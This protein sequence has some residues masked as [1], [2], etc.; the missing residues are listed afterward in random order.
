MNAKRIL[1]FLLTVWIGAGAVCSHAEPVQPLKLDPEPGFQGGVALVLLNYSAGFCGYGGWEYKDRHQ[2]YFRTLTPEGYGDWKLYD[3]NFGEEYHTLKTV[4]DTRK[5]ENGFDSTGRAMDWQSAYCVEMGVDL[6]GQDHPAA[7][8]EAF[9]EF[10]GRL[11]K[12]NPE[13][14]KGLCLTVL[15][16]CTF[17]GEI[18]EDGGITNIRMLTP[19]PEDFPQDANEVD[20]YMATNMI[21]YEFVMGLRDLNGLV[22]TSLCPAGA[23]QLKKELEG[24]PAARV[25]DW[26]I[27]RIARHA[28]PPSF[29]SM[30]GSPPVQIQLNWSKENQ[31]YEALL[32]DTNRTELDLSSWTGQG[33]QIEKAGSYLYRVWTEE[34]ISQQTATIQKPRSNLNGQNI[35]LWNSGSQKQTL[36]TGTVS[37]DPLFFSGVFSTEQLPGQIEGTKTDEEGKGLQGVTIGLF[38]DEREYAR[39]ITQSDGS[40]K[41]EAVP[42]GRYVVREIAALAGYEPTEQKY[43]VTVDRS[44]REIRIP[45]IL[46]KIQ[47]GSA[48]IL[49]KSEDGA[50][51]GFE[52]LLE[53][54]SDA[55]KAVHR[56]ART[57]LT[58]RALLED[59]PAGTYTI[60]EI[61]NEETQR[62]VPAES[63]RI[64]I[65]SNSVTEVSFFNRLKK[66]KVQLF[67]ADAE[68]PD[69][70][71]SGAVFEVSRDGQR[72]GILEE[73]DPGHYV[74]DQLPAGSYEL[75][76][77]EAPP[78]YAADPEVYPFSITEDGEIVTIENSSGETIHGFFNRAAT[79]NLEIIKIVEKDDFR[80]AGSG[81]FQF[82]V[83]G[84]TDTGEEWNQVYETD[85]DGRILIENLKT[86]EYT[87]TELPSEKTEGMLLPEDRTIRI[88]E[89]KTEKA[90]FENRWIRGNICL[91]KADAEFP[92]KRLQGAVFEIQSLDGSVRK[93]LQEFPDG[94]YRYEDLAYGSYVIREIKA[95]EHYVLPDETFPIEIR[96]DGEEIWIGAGEL[97]IVANEPERG[98]LIIHKEVEEDN[99][100]KISAKGFRFRVTGQADTGQTYDQTF[101]TDESGSIRVKN[102][103]T[104]LYTISE[105]ADGQMERLFD[106]PPDQTVRLEAGKQ[107]EVFVQNKLRRGKLQIF[108]ASA[109]SAQQRLSGAEFVL[110]IMKNNSRADYTEVYKEQGTWTEI[111]SKE[112]GKDGTLEFAQLVPGHYRLTETKSPEGYELLTE[113]IC[114][115]IPSEEQMEYEISLN[116]LNEPSYQLPDTGG[117]GLE[118]GLAAGAGLLGCA[119]LVRK[120]RK[121]DDE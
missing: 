62:Y 6:N 28:Q 9:S 80:Q 21:L 72:I 36:L 79:G 50:A 90:E 65:K 49:K 23:G 91:I 54:I 121:K 89:G 40:W 35:L 5:G 19:F 81:G 51:E 60:S 70:P 115:Q 46:N 58:G 53:G 20:W 75:K 11:R 78:F 61:R 113:S 56:T 39:S 45:P 10:A 73:M 97:N 77:I 98:E 26:M 1:L 76:E 93:L 59:V 83:Q 82:R 119:A 86:G 74:L 33:L 110:E 67:K 87:I 31:R 24:S 14:W 27:S 114:F 15:Y 16:G 57:D 37:E 107:S 43:E 34:D 104:G 101:I 88:R 111:G 116:I 30:Q 12:Y 8:D 109:V 68:K 102:L 2:C 92:E 117:N 48:K 44:H 42:W 99:T 106:I 118:G 112:T 100:L 63:Q 41:F 29:L 22:S 17:Q 3:S 47:K 105:I 95:P 108:K 18:Y 7:E 25:Y 69:R 64:T 38:Q 13:G 120:K 66:G 52:F 103:R 84:R 85:A 94:S 71:L 96:N 4:Y 32:E 55:G